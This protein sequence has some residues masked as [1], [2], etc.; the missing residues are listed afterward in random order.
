M[1]EL[2]PA[3]ARTTAALPLF[4]WSLLAVALVLAA[5]FDLRER[6]VP[7]WLAVAT[8]AAGLGARGLSVGPWGAALGVAGAAALL[9]LL[10]YPF[11][12]R[13]LGAGDVKLLCAV[14]GWLGPALAIELLVLTAL[15]AGPLAFAFWRLSPTRVRGEVGENL[16]A[17]VF[18]RAVPEVS[19]GREAR[20]HLPLALAVA[21]GALAVVLLRAR[22]LVH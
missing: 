7:N 19:A 2:A 11:A 3:L 6:R 20:L 5:I 4:H 21:A 17:A 12:R 18:A 16:K 8:L 14:G 1:L 15:A 10:L 22:L 13:W 9:A